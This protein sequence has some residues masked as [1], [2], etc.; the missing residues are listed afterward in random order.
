[1]LL[2]A[3]MTL[4]V[5]T[6]SRDDR[7][8]TYVLSTPELIPTTP[9]EIVDY[10]L[11]EELLMWGAT[12]EQLPKLAS[13]TVNAATEFESL[14]VEVSE[15]GDKVVITNVPAGRDDQL[16][17][18]EYFFMN[19]DDQAE[20]FGSATNVRLYVRDPK[21]ADLS[22]QRVACIPERQRIFTQQIRDTMLNKFGSATV[23][24]FL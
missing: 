19:S 1:M 5:E 14:S 9:R 16:D 6:P 18:R 10:L 15:L 22:K 23:T 20:P 12:V 24:F 11:T 3:T 17:R 13:L 21:I 2:I 4:A 7:D 8:P